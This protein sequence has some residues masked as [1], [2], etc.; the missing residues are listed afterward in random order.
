MSVYIYK[1]ILMYI[2]RMA[3]NVDTSTMI[4]LN[5][6]WTNITWN[7]WT[8]YN[9]LL[10]VFHWTNAGVMLMY[11][12]MEIFFLLKASNDGIVYTCTLVFGLNVFKPRTFSRKFCIYLSISDNFMYN[13]WNGF[14]KK[15]NSSVNG[16]V[17]VLTSYR[18][19]ISHS[20]LL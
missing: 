14:S 3:N 17:F 6:I 18:T 12:E 1:C 13:Y 15:E 11:Y 10:T 16:H 5:Y 19:S 9:R 20:I 2:R 4:V 7:N 8:M